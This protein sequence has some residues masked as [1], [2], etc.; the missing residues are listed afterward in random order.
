MAPTLA[1][2]YTTIP[3][4]SLR[5]QIAP[6]T[7]LLFFGF[8][9]ETL[10]RILKGVLITH[11]RASALPN[12]LKSAQKSKVF[13]IAFLGT[14]IYESTKSLHISPTAN[15]DGGSRGER[16]RGVRMAEGRVAGEGR[17]M[18]II[19]PLKFQTFCPIISHLIVPWAPSLPALSPLSP[20]WPVASHH[21]LTWQLAAWLFH[22]GEGEWKGRNWR[23]E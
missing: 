22:N 3:R 21:R 7:L 23:E 16:A 4:V 12:S 11:V 15:V 13:S 6:P 1:A 18:G 14:S 19:V 10:H 17:E 2:V 8:G 5:L 20:R 9:H